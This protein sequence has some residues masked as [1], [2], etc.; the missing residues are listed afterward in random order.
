M[1]A[2]HLAQ[3][4]RDQRLLRRVRQA[5]PPPLRGQCLQASVSAAKLTLVTGSAAW[6]TRLRF[7]APDILQGLADK[8]PGLRECRVRIRPIATGTPRQEDPSRAGATLS[9]AA[10]SHLISAAEG[11]S[12]PALAAA[13]RQLAFSAERCASRHGAT[14]RRS[15]DQ[16]QRDPQRNPESLP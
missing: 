7:M 9:P 2:A 16:A 8:W 14:P 5:L 6:A 4:E 11:L 1:L 13:L 15:P 3:I 12:D 10:V